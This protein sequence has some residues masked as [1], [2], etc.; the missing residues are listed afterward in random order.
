MIL[1]DI[2]AAKEAE[3]DRLRSR[4]RA[5]REEAE[6]APPARDLAGALRTGGAV[7]VIAE[8]KRRSPSA[9]PIATAADPAEVAAAYERGGAAAVSVLTDGPFFGGSLEDLRAARE[10]CDLPVLRKD[11]HL[12]PLQ[13]LEARAA[14]ADGVLL[15]VRVLDADRLADLLALAAELGMESL[16]EVQEQGELARALAVGA[17]V[18]GVNARNLADFSVRRGA[19]AAILAAVPSTRIAVAESGI[20]GPEDADLAARAGADALL[21]GGWLMEGSPEDRVAGLTG[22]PRRPRC[23]DPTG[24]RA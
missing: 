10:A 19:A 22:H 1:D 9:G 7:S 18:V 15:I 14:G 16:V 21:V 24:S 11:F 6:A 4:A 23:T 3:V 12:D 2:L 13:L 17:L 20:R 5:L 8:F